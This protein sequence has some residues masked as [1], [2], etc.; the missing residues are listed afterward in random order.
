M[1]KRNKGKLSLV[2]REATVKTRMNRV[3]VTLVLKDDGA[4]VAQG[5]VL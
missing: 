5:F 3:A 4:L 2:G 1:H